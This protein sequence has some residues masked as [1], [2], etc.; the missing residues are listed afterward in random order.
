MK[1]FNALILLIAMLFSSS[2]LYAEDFNV[3]GIYY[4]IT[5]TSIVE[6]TYRGEG[7]S[8][9][10][11][12]YSGSIVIPETVI[13]EGEKYSVESIGESAFYHCSGLTSV[14]IPNS[15]T[16]IGN[17]A[18]FGCSGLTSLTIPNSVTSIGDNASGDDRVTKLLGIML[19]KTNDGAF[20]GCSGLTSIVVDEGNS[21]Y[22]SRNNCNAI[23]ETSTNTLIL[24]CT[25]TNIPNSVESIGESAFSGCPG[26][27]S[28]PIPN[29]V[30]SIGDNAFDACSGLTSITIPNSVTSIGDKAFSSCFG[31]TSLPIPNSVTSIGAFAFY[32][33]SGLTSLTIPNSVKSIG[34]KAF[35]G[36]SGLTSIVVDEGNSVYD[37]R[38][39]CNAIIETSTNTLISGCKTTKIPNS[40]TSIGHSAF[41]A[42]SGLTSV[43]I[44]NSVTSI[45]YLAFEACLGLTSIVV[46]EGN[47]VYD[48]RNNC[49]AIIETS[50]NT[51]ISGCKTTNIPNSVTSIDMNAF[52]NCKSLTSITIPN[53]VTSIGDQAF[54]ACDGLT[55]V[56]IGNSVTSIGGSAFHGCKSLT[57]ITIPNSVT[58]IGSYAFS[59]CDGLT[60]ITIPNSVTSIGN[61]A[62]S[63][64]KSLTSVTI[65]NSVTNAGYYAFS[66]CTNLKEVYVLAENPVECSKYVFSAETYSNATL[67]VPEASIS[68]Y[69]STIPWSSFSSIKAN[70]K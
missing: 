36:C 14:T 54:F 38:N 65:G 10:D 32:N 34:N 56:K 51:L 47:S 35:F 37:S 31:L 18:F 23:I 7:V 43:E 9:Y 28:L 39:N 53:S 33:C 30:T 24:G 49:N 50:T 64:C 40:V 70:P 15:V 59:G 3:D 45:D 44:P 57:S 19:G 21:V 69:K 11:N 22:D 13:Y 66:K 16:S 25:T 61:D 68:S 2:S 58:S 60:S 12:E 42:C 27:T 4:N 8:S 46:D 26:L 63:N 20:F 6:V 1:I 41:F 17:K 62:F 5:N 55:S 67:Y 52:S 29:S 48:S